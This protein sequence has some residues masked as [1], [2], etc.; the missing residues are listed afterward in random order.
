VIGIKYDAA[1]VKGFNTPSP[2]TVHY[3]FQLTGVP[4]SVE[5]LDLVKKP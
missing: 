4:A 5:G 2:T 1:S 3:D